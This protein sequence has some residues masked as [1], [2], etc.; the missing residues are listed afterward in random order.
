MEEMKN[1]ST[2]P[3][4][5][6]KRGV[7]GAGA[8]PCCSPSEPGQAVVER[9]AGQSG[10]RGAGPIPA[11]PAA[12]G[13]E[14]A[15]SSHIPRDA[16]HQGLYVAMREGVLWGARSLRAAPKGVDEV[17][18]N[19]PGAVAVTLSLSSRIPSRL[20]LRARPLDVRLLPDPAGAGKVPPPDGPR[21]VLPELPPA[22]APRARPG[23]RGRAGLQEVTGPSPSAE[24]TGT[25]GGSGSSPAARQ[26][27]GEQL[28]VLLCRH[29]VLL[30]NTGKAPF[31]VFVLHV[32]VLKPSV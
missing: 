17:P 31:V 2:A 13:A 21:P 4:R 29:T 30:Q 18:D 8:V 10:A 27:A 19:R 32:T 28:G 22:R 1:P 20:R 14:A 25:H 26:G 24:S 5:A 7:R 16:G 15:P 23:P 6:C 3:R 12:G 9:A 11:A